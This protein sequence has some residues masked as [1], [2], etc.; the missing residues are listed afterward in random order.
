MS[1]LWTP[2]SNADLLDVIRKVF[3]AVEK[4]RIEG[5]IGFILSTYMTISEIQSFLV[6]GGLN[7]NDFDAFI[8]Q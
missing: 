1:L 7:A 3:E 4:E 2:D 5:S 6:S 8:W